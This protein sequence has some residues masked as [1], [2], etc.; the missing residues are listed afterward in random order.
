ML[1]CPTTAQIKVFVLQLKLVQFTA[2]FCGKSPKRVYERF[3][4]FFFLFEVKH[5]VDA[6]PCEVKCSLTLAKS[7]AENYC[8]MLVSAIQN[9]PSNVLPTICVHEL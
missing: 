2:D 1:G 8:D 5:G 7:V 4:F 3:F 6:K 9:W